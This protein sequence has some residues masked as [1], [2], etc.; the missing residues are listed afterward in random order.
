MQEVIEYLQMKNHY[1][2][3]FYS[4]TCKFLEQVENNNWDDIQF[5][6]DN[7]ERLLN[8]IRSFDHKIAS[9]FE[10]SKLS[11]EQM[12]VLKP[13]VKELLNKRA[14]LAQRIVAKDLHL[15]SRIDDHKSD[16]I[17]ELKKTVETK[18]QLESFT[19]RGKRISKVKD[20]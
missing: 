19:P 8:I 5:F 16:T 7:R 3:K 12:D 20:I 15:I 17:R 4:L 1:Y 2:E 11:D 13:Q 10:N 6:V 18:E 14:S 9:V